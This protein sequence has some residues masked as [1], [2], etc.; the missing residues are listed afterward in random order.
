MAN[1]K[2]LQE[3]VSADNGTRSS[4]HTGMLLSPLVVSSVYSWLPKT[5]DEFPC[6]MPSIYTMQAHSIVA[7]HKLSQGSPEPSA[8]KQIASSA[9]KLVVLKGRTS[10]LLVRTVT[11]ISSVEL[12]PGLY[13][14]VEPSSRSQL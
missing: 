6:V 10:R 2:R 14:S 7:M 3:S 9:A 12:V 5:T 13:L 11:M 8:V 4:L 1:H